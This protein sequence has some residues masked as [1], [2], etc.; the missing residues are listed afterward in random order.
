MTSA[1]LNPFPF[2]TDRK[3]APLNFGFVY[4]GEPD[5]DPQLFPQA[6]FWDEGLSDPAAQ[7]LRTENGY[8]VDAGTA[9]N[10]YAAGPYSIRIR[11]KGGSQVFYRAR[12]TGLLD[13]LDLPSGA[14]LLGFSQSQ[15]Y[16][17]GTVGKKLQ[18]IVNAQD[19][20]YRADPTGTID[21]TAAIQAAATSLPYGGEV[22]LGRGNFK[23]SSLTL[24]DGVIV[25]GDGD[26]GTTLICTSAIG[27]ITLGVS[28]GVK[29]LKIAANVAR[30]PDYEFVL[31]S[32]NAG[33][34]RHVVFSNYSLAIRAGTLAGAIVVR[35]VI[36]TCNFFNPVVGAGTGAIALDH[37]SNGIVVNC[38]GAGAAL[39]AQQPDF[40]VRLRNGDTSYL[41]NNNFTIHGNALLMDAPAGYNSYATA[42][43]NCTWDSAGPISG[44]AYA[45]S[46]AIVPAGGV[47]DTSFVNTW[48]GLATNKSG[49]FVEAQGAGVVDGL[50]FTG[51][52]FADNGDSG[53]LVNGAG[54]KNW[55]VTG[56][57]SSGS[58]DAG[59][60]A[61]GGTS[62]FS[63][64]GHRAGP[65]AGRG[66]NNYGIEV[67]IGAS[68]RYIIAGNNVE[69]N[70]TSNLFDGGTGADARVVDNLGSSG[71]AAPSA[72]TVGA[73]P[74][75]YTAA[76]TPEVLYIT[77]GTVSDIKQ[78]GVTIASATGTTVM[79]RP[80]GSCT[81]TYS[82]TPTIKKKLL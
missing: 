24:P 79:L 17:A 47:Y 78:D 68:D 32:K 43:V 28:S 22:S 4:I 8:V 48:A 65:V 70:N 45:S 37:Y 10:F 50:N 82:S 62:D 20:P 56:G 41:V 53:L 69:G 12:V 39:P 64:T 11:D 61:A 1:I 33:F 77:G 14:G 7:P 42:C 63:I 67:N 18:Q 2:L 44:G 29:D 23:Y 66:A 80:N 57:Y 76:H 58:G 16:G 15:S 52:Q 81:V 5:H 51:M 13:D 36:D 60:R 30:T 59:I 35:P 9:A 26:F 21:A 74:Y 25:S 27:K 49:C 54:V 46:I 71:A 19:A 6:V 55:N 75:T 31:I 38:T 3:G 72:V 73:S 40:G 34:C